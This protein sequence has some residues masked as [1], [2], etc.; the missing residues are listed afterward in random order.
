[1]KQQRFQNFK[2]INNFFLN[3]G[4]QKGKPIDSLKIE[5]SKILG[6]ICTTS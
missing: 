5:L 4:F 3:Q 2:S 1:L 6:I